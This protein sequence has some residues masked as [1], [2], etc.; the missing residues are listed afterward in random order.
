MSWLD[1]YVEKIED[2]QRERGR[3]RHPYL[4]TKDGKTW[5]LKQDLEGCRPLQVQANV[6]MN[7]DPRRL[8][9]DAPQKSPSKPPT[10]SAATPKPMEHPGTAEI[11]DNC[12]PAPP[13]FDMLDL[14]EAMERMG[15]HYAAHCARRWFNGKAHIAPRD[16]RVAFDKEFVD[17]ESCKLKWVL[18]W[19]NVRAR[20]EHLIASNLHA[21]ANENIYNRRARAQLTA[22]LQ[23]FMERHNQYY[24]GTLDAMT[25]SLGE[26][27][28]LH[29]EFQFQQVAISI[30]D[31]LGSPTL[32]M[33]DLAASMA[34]FHLY[35][36]VAS[37]KL[38]TAKYMRY[39]TSPWG[40]CTQTKATVTH[41]YVYAK[42]SYSFNDDP[43]SNAS[44]YLGHWNQGGVIIAGDA[45]M[46]ET[47]AKITD[48]HHH[49]ELGNEPRL[50]LPPMPRHLDNAIDRGHRMRKSEVY[51]P[52]RNQD[53]QVWRTRKGRGGD[54]LIYSDFERVK[55]DKPIELDLGEVCREYTE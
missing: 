9:G 14:P 33:N 3:D 34:N 31:A 41:I 30:A 21:D 47:F 52:V 51:Y 13:P 53:F 29:Q 24:S 4:T 18:R 19:G 15:F 44:Q 42:D 38:S 2:Y 27:Q 49:Q 39:N 7:K 45:A 35:A 5:F 12:A 16:K 25:E 20:C 54:F 8:P 10:A 23:S 6:L 37:V 28:K 26:K 50:Y 55:L 40:V 32:L 17:F 36:A 1:R 48:P 46:A 43:G 11:P 22:N